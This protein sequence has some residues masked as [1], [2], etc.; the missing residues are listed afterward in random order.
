MKFSHDKVDYKKAFDSIEINTVL[1]SLEMLD[2][3]NSNCTTD[4][5]LLYPNIIILV[6]RHNFP[7]ALYRMSWNGHSRHWQGGWHQHQCQVINSLPIHRWYFSYHWNHQS[8]VM[9]TELNNQSLSVNHKIN[10][11]KM[12]FM[13]SKDVPKGCIV[14]G[15]WWNWGDEEGKKYIYLVNNL[16]SV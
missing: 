13:H 1:S 9:M 7:K 3:V 8:E 10:S 16:W 5:V 2:K 14:M 4:I 6:G 12:Q 11:M 15:E